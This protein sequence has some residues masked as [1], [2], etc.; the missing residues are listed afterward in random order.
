MQLHLP[1]KEHINY[2]PYCLHIWRP[3]LQ[4]KIPRPPNW[5]IVD[6]DKEGKK[7]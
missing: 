6:V 3:L 5:M 7:P 2:H 1:V 4:V